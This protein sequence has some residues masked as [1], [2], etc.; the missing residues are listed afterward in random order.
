M[1]V[2]TVVDVVV[3]KVV[4]E[5]EV[6]EVDVELELEL[7]VFESVLA[8]ITDDNNPLPAELIALTL[9]S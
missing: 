9:K 7:V 4:V 2:G 3:A 8:L 6:L 1:V 5:V